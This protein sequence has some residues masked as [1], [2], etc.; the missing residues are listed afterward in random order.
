MIKRGEK[1]L[2]FTLIELMVVISIL[3]FLIVAAVFTFSIVRIHSRDALRAG[4]A[5]T[6]SRALALYMNDQATYPLSDG[7]CLNVSFGAGK[8]MKDANVI[9]DIPVDPLWPTAVPGVLNAEG[10]AEGA[11]NNFC[12]YYTGT[13]KNY[14]LSYYLES[15]SKSGAAGIHVITP[16]GV[17]N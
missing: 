2:G 9:V 7:E 8:D 5:A 6:F 1:D 16:L 13:N 17:Q 3:G 15:S 4:N 14:Y 11:S 12:Y 10:Y